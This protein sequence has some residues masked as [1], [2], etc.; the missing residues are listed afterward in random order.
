MIARRG[1]KAARGKAVAPKNKAF[2]IMAISKALVPR[3]GFEPR[4][5]CLKG[6]IN[7][8]I[9]NAYNGI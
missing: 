7:A 3:R 1:G 5:P 6:T 8:L 2:E 4:T 9:S